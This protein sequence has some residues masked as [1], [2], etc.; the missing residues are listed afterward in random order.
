MTMKASDFVYTAKSIATNY[1][2][3][4]VMGGWGAPLTPANKNRYINGYAYNKQAS[5]AE[6]IR[7]A[8]AN[9]FAFD[10][11]CLIK[12]ILWGWYGNANA[13]NGGAVYASNGVPDINADQMINRCAGV[14][15]DFSNIQIGE[16]VWKSGH[17]GVYIGNGLAVECTPAWANKVQITAVLNIGAKKGFNGRYWTSHGKL[18]WITYNVEET[19]SN[20]ANT[21]DKYT[22]E[23]LADKVI[24]GEFG[25]GEARKKA[26]GNRYTAVQKI[27]DEKLSKKKS[28]EEIAKEVIEGKWG[29][30]SAR[31]TALTKAGYDYNAVQKIVDEKLSASK[32]VYY[33]VQKGDT[34]TAIAKKYGTTWQKIKK[35]NGLAN[36]NLI[37]TGQKLR[38][39]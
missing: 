15:K 10:C 22:N 14:S 36:A 23:Q 30:G 20:G 1:K 34:L 8:S 38:V 2:T 27:V 35:L 25:N 12:G 33:T 19:G 7:S 37:Y 29:N 17:I 31:K 32:A 4:Y 5:R 39:K 9:T 24:N 13:T 6:M 28:N 18:P 21:L 26:L 11:V 16:A 3:L